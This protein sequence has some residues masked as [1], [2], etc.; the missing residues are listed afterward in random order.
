MRTE[1]CSGFKDPD[2][3]R[4]DQRGRV[5]CPFLYQVDLAKMESQVSKEDFKKLKKVKKKLI[6][7]WD[8]L[9]IGH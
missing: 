9:L 5:D 8:Y 6:G 2:D 4:N 1:R 7:T 3:R